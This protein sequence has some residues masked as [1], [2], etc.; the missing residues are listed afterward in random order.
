MTCSFDLI[1][2]SVSQVM[3]ELAMDGQDVP[4]AHHTHAGLDSTRTF[5]WLFMSGRSLFPATAESSGSLTSKFD[6]SEHPGP[7]M[8]PRS[9]V[10]G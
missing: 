9:S 4:V 6:F 1:C 2:V 10:R 8:V 7:G 5:M 3:T